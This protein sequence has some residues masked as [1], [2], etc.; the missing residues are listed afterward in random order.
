M[1]KDEVDSLEF[2]ISL[3]IFCLFVCLFVFIT[4]SRAQSLSLTHPGRIKIK[5]DI[6]AKWNPGVNKQRS[7]A[8]IFSSFTFLDLQLLA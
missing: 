6:L 2:W 4:E 1:L 3:I 5:N 7:G 8:P